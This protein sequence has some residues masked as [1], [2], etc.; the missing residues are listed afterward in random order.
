MIRYF[1]YGSNMSENRMIKRG[2]KPSGKQ[3][4]VLYDYTFKINKRSY[5][6]PEIGFANIVSEKYS[7]VEGILYEVKDEEINILDKFEGAPKHYSRQIMK[8]R[9][10]NGSDVDAIVYVATPK[11]T[12]ENELKTTEEYKNFILEGKEWLSDGYYQKLNENIQI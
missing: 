1:A 9:L 5:K 6:N 3:I 12:T 2:L 4:G 8:V 7:F 11:W 10:D